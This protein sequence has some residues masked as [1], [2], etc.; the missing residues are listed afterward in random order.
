MGKIPH[1]LLLTVALV[2][3]SVS[4]NTRLLRTCCLYNPAGVSSSDPCQ[5]RNQNR[6]TNLN[7]SKVLTPCRLLLHILTSLPDR[8]DFASWSKSSVCEQLLFLF[9]QHFGIQWAYSINSRDPCSIPRLGRSPGGGNDNLL[10][11][12]CLENLKD[13]GAWWATV[14]PQRVGHN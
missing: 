5:K 13:R 3:D 11:Y 9:T 6:K 12:S 14:Q 10:Q 7:F 8:L 1:T 2:L 4:T